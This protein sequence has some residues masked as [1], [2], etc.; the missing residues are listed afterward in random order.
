MLISKLLSRSISDCTSSSSAGQRWTVVRGS[1]S[2]KLAS[3]N[4]CLDAGENPGNGVKGKIWTVS[5][6]CHS[7]LPCVCL[8]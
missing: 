6:C 7:I 8:R 3:S 5:L 1:T 2:V 4:F